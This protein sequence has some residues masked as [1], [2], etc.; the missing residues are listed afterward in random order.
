[1]ASPS[2][3]SRPVLASVLVPAL[4]RAASLAPPAE[5]SWLES[6]VLVGLVLLTPVVLG[7][8]GVWAAWRTAHKDAQR[9]G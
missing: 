4:A 8:A 5:A 7:A 6:S 3:L 1:M 9:D 2:R